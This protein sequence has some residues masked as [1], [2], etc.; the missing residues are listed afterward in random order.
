VWFAD[1][2]SSIAIHENGTKHKE[3]VERRIR[4]SRKKNVEEGA[5]QAEMARTMKKI[6]EEA[7]KK[8]QQDIRD[9][10]ELQHD[11][12]YQSLLQ[13]RP[14]APG[15]SF[16]LDMQDHVAG[17]DWYRRRTD[18]G[19]TFYYNS[20][21]QETAWELPGQGDKGSEKKK[22]TKEKKEG[23]QVERSVWLKQM[24]DNG[25]EYFYNTL[26]G[27]SQW[28]KPDD[29][30]AKVPVAIPGALDAEGRLLIRRRS[31]E[32]NEHGSDGAEVDGAGQSKRARVDGEEG[33]AADAGDGEQ[34]AEGQTDAKKEALATETPELS[35]FGKWQTVTIAPPASKTSKAAR[36]EGESKADEAEG[37]EGD[38]PQ[39]VD[40]GGDGDHAAP[41]AGKAKAGVEKEKT[42]AERKEE[43]KRDEGLQ[44]AE[45]VTPALKRP[46][47]QG[48]VTFV[49]KKAS[50][51]MRPRPRKAGPT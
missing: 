10:P 6:E 42:I 32:E 48:E 50:G 3:A 51:N 18:E 31:E 21:T 1:N 25:H 44:F 19:H 27:A 2:K 49:A 17:T 36:E 45:K 9:N 43:E 4:D 7:L 33:D 38:A 28:E 41:A 24:A 26:T 5:A 40:A 14:K 29:I 12:S 11:S 37:G 22:K 16:D 20:V 34:G 39:A 47:Q 15:F 8:M 23:G 35:V 46:G 30:D 13:K